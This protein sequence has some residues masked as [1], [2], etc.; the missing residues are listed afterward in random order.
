MTFI[1]LFASCRSCGVPRLISSCSFALWASLSSD[2]ISSADF[3][4]S[5][6]LSTAASSRRTSGNWYPFKCSKRC[7]SRTKPRS[8]RY[9]LVSQM[10][11]RHSSI[12]SRILFCTRVLRIGGRSG[13]RL[14]S[15]F[16]KS[17]VEI[18]K[19]NGYPQFLTQMSRSERASR[20]TFG[21]RWLM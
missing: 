21:L 8:S 12:S 3:R 13:K 15:S 5:E 20:L 2:S 9:L 19:W 11:R 4:L 16:K 14:T 18:C 17:L 1:S 7:M 10:V 6:G